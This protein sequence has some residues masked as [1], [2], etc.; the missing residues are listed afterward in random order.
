MKNRLILGEYGGRE[1]KMHFEVFRYSD[2]AG[3]IDG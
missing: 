3:E 1:R 2:S